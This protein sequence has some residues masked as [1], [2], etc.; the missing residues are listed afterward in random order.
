[1]RQMNINKGNYEVKSH[2]KM[3]KAG[4]RW[5]V[6]GMATVSLLGGL[7]MLSADASADNVDAVVPAS[8][9]SVTTQVSAPTDSVVLD[10]ASAS[11]APASSVSAEVSA[12]SASSVAPVSV[13]TAASVVSADASL[14][15]SQSLASSFVAAADAVKILDSISSDGNSYQGYALANKAPLEIDSANTIATETATTS[16]AYPTFTDSQVAGKDTTGQAYGSMGDQ[17]DMK[18]DIANLTGKSITDSA[19]KSAIANINDANGLTFDSIYSGKM[20]SALL[21]IFSSEVVKYE[22]KSGLT[23]ITSAVRSSLYESVGNSFSGTSH[24]VYTSYDYSKASYVS[25]YAGSNAE[26]YFS[27]SIHTVYTNG[28]ANAGK[29]ASATSLSQATSLANSYANATNAL[30]TGAASLVD[31]VDNLDNGTDTAPSVW[32]ALTPANAKNEGAS[33][34]YNKK[35]DVTSDFTLRGGYAFLPLVVTSVTGKDGKVTQVLTKGTADAGGQ[36]VGVVLS[37]VE[38][39]DMGTPGIAGSGKLNN[40]DAIDT[41]QNAIIAGRDLFVNNPGDVNG[42]LVHVRSTDSNGY[43]V[44]GVLDSLGKVGVADGYAYANSY[45]LWDGDSKTTYTTTDNKGGTVAPIN[46]LGQQKIDVSSAIGV[47]KKGVYFNYVWHVKSVDRVSHKVTATITYTEYEDATMTREL[48]TVSTEVVSDESMS[49]GL[50]GANGGNGWTVFGELSYFQGTNKINDVNVSYKFA[51]SDEDLMDST[52]IK[53]AANE[54]IQIKKTA[55]ETSNDDMILLY[56]A[57][58]VKG[59]VIDDSSELSAVSGKGDLTVKYKVDT[60]GFQ[61][62]VTTAKNVAEKIQ[63]EID[64]A[65][66]KMNA[67]P[68]KDKAVIQIAIDQMQAEINNLQGEDGKSG[69]IDALTNATSDSTLDDLKTVDAVVGQYNSVQTQMTDITALGDR[70]SKLVNAVDALLDKEDADANAARDAAKLLGDSAE[71]SVAKSNKQFSDKVQKAQT[72]L[73]TTMADPNS[74]ASDI[75]HATAVLL[76]DVES[77]SVEHGTDGNV[78]E[79]LKKVEQAVANGTTDEINEATAKL[80]IADATVVPANIADDTDVAAAKT[81]VDKALATSPLDQKQLNESKANYDKAV[82]KANEALKDAKYAAG[83]TEENLKHAD[84]DTVS[85]MKKVVDTA[86]ATGTKTDIEKA[87]A[88][89]KVADDTAVVPSTLSDDP[90][91]KTAKQAINGAIQDDTFNQSRMVRLLI[92]P[93]QLLSCKL[94]MQRLCQQMFQMMMM[95]RLLRRLL[96]TH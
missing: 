88:N 4:K 72:D 43:L 2:Y 60:K 36:A 84:A 91:L 78:Q 19:Y 58:K 10:H 66:A 92:L 70:V 31:G 40:N 3:Y 81:A 20:S 16:G 25:V 39:S 21:S 11:V 62:N 57:P 26:N 38:P 89:L 28:Q 80:K 54:K 59:F 44:G 55:N 48:S 90:A 29:T 64:D 24:Y 51:K 68:E 65:V 46:K 71:K 34:T 73:D 47:L 77:E 75:E 69:L 17:F 27:S 53:A 79:L 33:I 35:L 96:T 52:S 67:A 37:P 7:L 41:M 8:E 93:R 15:A 45:N 61:N 86:V 6:A 14:S 82:S 23:S 18:G 56:D 63:G 30:K 13:S 1:M 50:Y 85:K 22:Y 9:S 5:V 76:A 94:L 32:Q 42:L 87:V 12:S 95:L 74:K 83:T 49:L